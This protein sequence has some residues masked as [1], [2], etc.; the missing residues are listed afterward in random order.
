MC[1][2]PQRSNR[3]LVAAFVAVAIVA[4]ACDDDNNNSTK[5]PLVSFAPLVNTVPFTTAIV[6]SRL[7]I[8]PVL[9]LG[10]PVFPSVTT[11]F[12]LVII[13][14][15]RDLFMNELT[16]RLLDGTHVGGSPLLVS[17]RDLEA[18]FG[19]TLIPAGLRRGFGF[20]PQFGCGRF[21]PFFLEAEV[22]LLERSGFRHA[23]TIVAPIGG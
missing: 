2:V 7:G 5:T 13:S 16:I 22:I 17:A 3:L 11:H 1:H 8:T 10:C 12:D 23:T 18:K 20:D 4:A 19:S 14:A 6:P 9:G 15:S 21:L